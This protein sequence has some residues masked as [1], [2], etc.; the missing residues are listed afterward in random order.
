MS[1]IAVIYPIKSGFRETD[2]FLFEKRLRKPV[3]FLSVN[4]VEVQ[5]LSAVIEWL[6]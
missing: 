4:P 3:I 1:L 5:N 6:F 2:S